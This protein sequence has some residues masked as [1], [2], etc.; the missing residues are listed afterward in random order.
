MKSTSSG[1]SMNEQCRSFTREPTRPAQ[2]HVLH[3][4]VSLPEPLRLAEFTIS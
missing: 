1:Q 2:G 3:M 4:L